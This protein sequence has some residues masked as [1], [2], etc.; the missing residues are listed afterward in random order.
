MSGDWRER[1]AC[2]NEDPEL[3][4]P[5]GTDGPALLQIVEA[6]AVCVACPVVTQCLTYA[7][8][9]GLDDGIW[10]GLTPEERRELRRGFNLSR[11]RTA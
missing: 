4:F 8:Q 5:T 9:H 10:A 6:K 7:L 3:W 1:A 11:A 2:R